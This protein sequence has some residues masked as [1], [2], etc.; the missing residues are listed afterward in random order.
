MKNRSADPQTDALG[1]LS[2]AG[3][4]RLLLTKT[5][6]A[7]SRVMKAIPVKTLKLRLLNKQPR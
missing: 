4:A 2:A 6:A 3:I 5:Q 7:K 1:I